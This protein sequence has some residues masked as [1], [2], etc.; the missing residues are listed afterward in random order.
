MADLPD[1][2]GLFSDAHR[3]YRLGLVFLYAFSSEITKPVE[4]DERVHVEYI[5]SQV[6]TEYIRD[7]KIGK[8]GF[9][10]I[11]YPSALKKKGSN[12]VLFATPENVEEADGS[13]VFDKGYGKPN[14][15]IRLKK[16]ELVTQ[17]KKALNRTS[18]GRGGK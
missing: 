2:P 3:E 14:R 11:R 10:G 17:K 7:A 15:W 4:R 13:P 16:T 5:P 1:V 9:D 18:K 8:R 12:I 6:V